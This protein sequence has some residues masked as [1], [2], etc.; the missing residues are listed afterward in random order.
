MS[1]YGNRETPPR[2]ALSQRLARS[3]HGA[4][5][6]E[7]AM[8]IGLLI[9][10]VLGILQVGLAIFERSSMERTLAKEIRRAQIEAGVSDQTLGDRLSER[11]TRVSDGTVAVSFEALELDGHDLPYRRVIVTFP[12]RLQIPPLTT[13]RIT[14][15]AEGIA[16]SIN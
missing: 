3:D 4:V 14:M 11:L 5:A 7:F 6:I 12:Y 9:M 13:L 2:A 15:R 16:R 8:V 1:G 10:L